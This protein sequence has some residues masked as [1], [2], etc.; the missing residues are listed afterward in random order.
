MPPKSY[1]RLWIAAAVVLVSVATGA[2]LMRGR[3][4]GNS[5]FGQSGRTADDGDGHAAGLRPRRSD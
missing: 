4:P 2:A 5:E 3:D 1:S